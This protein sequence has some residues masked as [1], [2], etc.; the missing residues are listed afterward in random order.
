ML[1][2]FIDTKEELKNV[3]KFMF[4]PISRLENHR[5]S[6]SLKSYEMECMFL[7]NTK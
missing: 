4:G 5:K 1:N 6:E 7:L 2:F 3:N